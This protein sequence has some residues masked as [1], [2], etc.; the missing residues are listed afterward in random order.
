MGKLSQT[1]RTTQG[2]SSLVL[3]H[4]LILTNVGRVAPLHL[5]PYT[6]LCAITW[7]PYLG[8]PSHPS[9]LHSNQC[10]MK[11]C[12]RCT[13]RHMRGFH[14]SIRLRIPVYHLCAMIAVRQCALRRNWR[15][16]TW[17]AWVRHPTPHSL[18]PIVN[19]TWNYVL[20]VT[21]VSICLLGC[22]YRYISSSMCTCMGW[23]KHECMLRARD[24]RD[25]RTMSHLRYSEVWRIWI[26]D[27]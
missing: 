27:V 7:Y 10:H 3:A 2:V 19:V 15:V 16:F 1:V 9:L 12:T 22:V 24:A 4:I 21:E 23:S 14:T 17:Y 6:D 8:P 11:L 20:D 26:L 25:N 13:S 5:H 18:I